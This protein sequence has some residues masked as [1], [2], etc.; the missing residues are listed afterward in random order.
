MTSGGT[1]LAIMGGTFDPVHFGH[2]QMAVEAREALAVDTVALIPSYYS[3]HRQDPG[4]DAEM[5]AHMLALAVAGVEGLAVDRLELERKGDSYSLDT[6]NHFRQRLGEQVPIVLLLGEDAFAT[7][8]EWHEWETLV[9]RVHLGIIRR[10]GVIR[11][12]PAKLKKL[13][14]QRCLSNPQALMCS[15]GGRLAYLDL[16]PIGISA[17]LVRQRIRAGQ[18]I[19]FLVPASVKTYIEDKQLYRKTVC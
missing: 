6:V 2:L 8:H 4:I 17:S 9:D 12:L 19:D 5:R 14:A 7:L 11:R 16:T 13:I 18:S 10:Q 15:P 3:Y 1:G